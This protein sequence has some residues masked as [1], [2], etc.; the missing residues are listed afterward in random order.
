MLDR[1]NIARTFSEG[2]ITVLTRPVDVPQ[3]KEI[4]NVPDP[5][6][7]TVIHPDGDFVNI[8]NRTLVEDPQ[9]RNYLPVVLGKHAVFL[10][11]AV[12]K[13]PVGGKWVK[14]IS[15]AIEIAS[16]VTGIT[17]VIENM[18]QHGTQ[19][20]DYELPTGL[21]AGAAVTIFR[22]IVAW[23][24]KYLVRRQFQRSMGQIR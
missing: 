9:L 16:Y 1:L 23:G 10:R 20:V 19:L 14:Q 5:L 11:D 6:V 21:V 17:E 7:R 8:V 3:L 12:P 18:I 24:I 13:G 22:Q 4:P 15:E 2:G